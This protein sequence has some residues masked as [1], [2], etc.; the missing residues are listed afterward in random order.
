M[1]NFPIFRKIST[2]E[3]LNAFSANYTR[4]SGFVVPF[5]YYTSN[6]VFAV[7]WRGQMAGGFVLGTGARLRTLEVFAG[8][9]ARPG[10]YNHVQQSKPH[11]EMCCFWMDPAFQKNTWLNFF[12][13]FCVAY[14]MWVFAS[15]Q[16][17]F[18]TN[19]VR[20]AA[21]YGSSPKC[22]MLHTDFINQKQTFIFSGP[23]RDCLTGV[24]QI[25][26]YKCKRLMRVKAF[27]YAAGIAKPSSVGRNMPPTTKNVL[28]MGKA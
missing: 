7:Y 25:M 5:E 20:L 26:W 4:C 17:I 21:L 16:L 18:G 11:T 6:Q 3:D 28:L 23:R 13:W 10:L 15:P 14:A 24:A 1:M 19:S 27:T 12:V 8:N 9:D 22:K 2:L